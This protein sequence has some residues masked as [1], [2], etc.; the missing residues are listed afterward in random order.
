MTMRG[1]KME[2]TQQQLQEFKDRYALRRRRQIGVSV[3]LVLCYG[4][5]PDM[6]RIW[7]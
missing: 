1:A 3:P 5:V 6:R 4:S 7:H 2:Y